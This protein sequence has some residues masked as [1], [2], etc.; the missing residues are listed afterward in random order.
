MRFARL[1]LV[2]LFLIALVAC[3]SRPGHSISAGNSGLPSPT[4]AMAAPS[5][6]GAVD[7][8]LL[9]ERWRVVKAA[10]GEPLLTVGDVVEFRT[11]GTLGTGPDLAPAGTWTLA[12]D[13]LQLLSASRSLAY[14]V[15][16]NSDMLRLVDATG[17]SDL[18]RRYDGAPQ[19]TPPAN[20]V[21]DEGA[22]FS[23][24]AQ[25]HVDSATVTQS[26]PT[27]TVTGVY[28]GGSGAARYQA[29][30]HN[31]AQ[32]HGL[33]AT[34]RAKGVLTDGMSPSDVEC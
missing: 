20:T 1:G 31:C 32:V 26:G 25:G 28:F 6:G 17:G 34:F 33:A 16:I 21:L 13:R 19:P 4:P 10:A 12:G 23:L 24:V 14:T 7:P 2:A 22:F 29:T 15:S 27:V 5:A 18:L 9:A 8:S 11:G 3:G 30:L